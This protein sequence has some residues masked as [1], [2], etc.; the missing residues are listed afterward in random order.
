MPRLLLSA[1]VLTA[2]VPA[3]ARAAA[4]DVRTSAKGDLFVTVEN[5]GAQPGD[6]NDLRVEILA[7]NGQIRVNGLNGTRVLGGNL[8]PF[9]TGSIFVDLTSGLNTH[10]ATVR[11][12]V[13]DGDLEVYAR[14]V[15]VS[16]VGVV[17]NTGS[18]LVVGGT[19]ATVY[20]CDVTGNLVVGSTNAGVYLTNVVG[21]LASTSADL[22]VA[23][24]SYV[25]GHLTSLYGRFVTLDDIG[26][27]KGITI[28]GTTTLGMDVEIT[29]V[30]VVES[31]E[32][33]TGGGAD[34]LLLNGVEG[35]NNAAVQ[36]FK[37]AT[38]GANDRLEI[39][40]CDAAQVDA[41]G[42]TGTDT[43]YQSGNLGFGLNAGNT[44]RIE[45][46]K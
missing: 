24:D 2:L 44:V 16:R 40:N 28:N 21:N 25:Y 10:S 17:A 27:G 13:L 45:W 4:I 29:D 33:G 20:D 38:N 34:K 32:I 6:P 36:R 35:P 31:V 30:T 23:L 9:P 1:L 41:D 14:N 39:R 5:R 15:L 42:G 46:F 19:S 11:D 22:T 37:F 7:Q 12:L 3:A 8:H 43:L 26:V 18:D